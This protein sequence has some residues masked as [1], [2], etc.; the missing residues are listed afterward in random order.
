MVRKRTGELGKNQIMENLILH[1]EE[2]YT[3]D[4]SIMEI[5]E[6]GEWHGHNFIGERT[7]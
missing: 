1:V 2:H 6:A 7:F 4:D 3:G 5:L